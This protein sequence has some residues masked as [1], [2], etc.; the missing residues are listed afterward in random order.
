[1]KTEESNTDEDYIVSKD[2]MHIALN[3]AGSLVEDRYEAAKAAYSK[4]DCT[5]A[6]ALMASLFLTEPWLEKMTV[7][8]SATAEYDDEGSCYRCVRVEVK[9][10][11]ALAGVDLPTDVVD[12]SGNFDSDSA[13]DL[14]HQEVDEEG[15]AYYEALASSNY[16]Y[17][18]FTIQL[19]R[20]Q[21][22]G[23]LDSGQISGRAA[24]LALF[25]EYAEHLTT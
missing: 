13:C 14:L 22:S 1:M 10:V 23:L 12:P 11:T 15:W 21:I 19:D 6:G 20:S 25:P 4:L 18:S 3:E 9:N 16:D 24:F 8:L 5:R 17:R 7:E 2:G